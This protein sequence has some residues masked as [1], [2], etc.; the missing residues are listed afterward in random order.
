MSIRTL[1]LLL[2]PFLW[3]SSLLQAQSCECTNCDLP[4]PTSSTIVA[5]FEVSGATNDD[6]SRADQGICG[7]VVDFRH[8]F[9]W[10]VEMFLISPSGQQIQ[11]IGPEVTPPLGSFT[12][13]A[14]WGVSFLPA[15]VAV[16]PD[17]GFN[18]TWDN[19]QN[20]QTAGR[21]TGS[22]YPY[23]GSLEDFNMGTV[24]G[25]WQLSIVNN[26]TFYQGI[27]N[28]FRVIFCDPDGL[29]CDDC[30]ADAGDLSAFPDVSDCEGASSLAFAAMPFY[31]SGTGP[32][33]TEYEYSYIV[34]NADTILA[35]Q[36]QP[37]LRTFPP[38]TY[39]IRGFSY[40]RADAAQ[41]PPA[42]GSNLQSDLSDLL[43]DLIN[44]PICGDLSVDS[45]VVT[46][47][48]GG[49]SN[50]RDT[51]CAGEEFLF[52]GRLLQQS[53]QYFDTIL[54]SGNCDSIV[55]LDLLVRDTFRTSLVADIC[56]G[57]SYPFGGES[58]GMTGTYL[59]TLVATTG[60]DSILE[61]TL[62]V[63]DT[64]AT[65]L[66]AEICQGDSYP[67]GGMQLTTTG[68]YFDTLQSTASCDSIL[69][70]SLLVND[71]VRQAQSARVCA[72]ETYSFGGLSLTQAG[73]YFDTLSTVA[74]CDSILVLTLAVSDTVRTPVSVQICEGESYSFDGAQLTQ[75]GLY[76]DTLQTSAGCDSLI[77]L[78]LLVGDTSR[79]AIAARV[80]E[81]SSYLFGGLSLTQAGIYF[82]TVQTLAGCDSILALSLA[83]S[84]TVHTPLSVQICEGES[85]SFGG[86]QLTQ[87][88][89]YFDTLSTIAGCDSILELSLTV[90]DTV[91]TLLSDQI[92]EGESYSFDGLQLTQSGIYYDTLQTSTGCDSLIELTL[93]VNDTVRTMLSGQICRGGIYLFDGVQLTQGGVY[94]DTLQTVAGCVG[95]LEGRLIVSDRGGTILSDK[96]W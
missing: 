8:D 51:I 54:L 5:E 31:S 94:F 64:F 41:L 10:S 57:D 18:V 65:P 25:T 45:I 90:S 78:T 39:A 1:L 6:L 95:M 91:R 26:S 56:Q 27:L 22:Y 68:T 44:P 92:C 69:I 36:T 63:N 24:N 28:D 67:F 85:Y 19:N 80:C 93:L 60:C 40:L 59:D 9:V 11:L 53:G 82:D 16:S 13:F 46:I 58:L 55:Q 17:P 49:R 79:T 38:G 83:V 42:N 71:T 14:V 81:G 20:W 72:G 88:G 47:T 52:D 21:Y 77:E 84:D 35:Y 2:M 12:G 87:G 62:V 7:V 66:T 89:T 61:L 32:D 29:D 43:I 30:Q 33:P 73:T 34:S 15:A 76:Y 48:S 74:G 3:C 75:S 4:I 37:D 50:L 86:V 23:N 96:V 70:L